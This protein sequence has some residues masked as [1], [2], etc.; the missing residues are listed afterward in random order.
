MVDSLPHLEWSGSVRR[1]WVG[2]LGFSGLSGLM[3]LSLANRKAIT[4]SQAVR[5]R[6]ASRAGKAVILDSVCAVTG[7]NRDYARRAL[8]NALRPKIV[9]AR[10]PRELKYG[11]TV[12]GALEKCWAVL[13]APAGKRLAPML[14]ELV[15]VLRRFGELRI[16]DD[17]A[18]LLMSMSAATI[19]RLRLMHRLGRRPPAEAEAEYYA[20]RHAGKHTGHM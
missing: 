11:A 5:Y 4:R 3:E 8:R 19:D 12:V 7:F 9:A 13:N 2:E 15:P 14:G 18:E 16:D 20:R 1:A 10:P 17:T 6:N